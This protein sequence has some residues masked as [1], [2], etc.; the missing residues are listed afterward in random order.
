M[1]THRCAFVGDQN[2]TVSTYPL[3]IQA[4]PGIAQSR[5]SWVTL[6]PAAGYAEEELN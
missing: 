2:P 1:E 5:G 4:Q 6:A 3:S